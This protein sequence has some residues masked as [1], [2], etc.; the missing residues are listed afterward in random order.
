[1]RVHDDHLYH[2]AALIQ[3]AEHPQFTAINSF[4]LRGEPNRSAYKVNDHIGVYLKYCVSPTKTFNEYPFT[5]LGSHL[6]TLN[7]MKAH[8]Q[9]VVI[10]LV[11][12]KDREICCVTLDELMELVQRR[13]RSK[14][15][16]EDQYI[17]KVTTPKGKSMRVY[18]DFPG[19][20]KTILGKAIVVARNRF[21]GVLFE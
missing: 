16:P 18:M 14:G 1:M 6:E 4:N 10:A 3:I 15:E 5:F 2:G 20:K 9:N 21:P 8:V 11:C 12:V 17:V 13:Q 7:E 19:K